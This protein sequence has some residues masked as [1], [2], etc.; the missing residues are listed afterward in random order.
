MQFPAFAQTRPW[1]KS[2]RELL[3]KYTSNAQ[4]KHSQH[5]LE[6]T[7]H[8][9]GV[10][11]LRATALMNKIKLQATRSAT[12]ILK[13]RRDTEH[14]PQKHLSN[15]FWSAGFASQPPDP[16]W[17]ASP[18][19]I[20]KVGCFVS[21]HPLGVAGHKTT[22]FPTLTHA[23]SVYAICVLFP[24]RYRKYAVMGWAIIGAIIGNTLS[25]VEP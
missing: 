12:E 24:F 3:G 17:K 6:N 2:F 8:S 21:L 18:N 20:L 25:W 10:T 4:C 16:H 7:L 15:T 23:V 22:S 5:G 1:L 19:F 14:T 11:G 13:M 9:L